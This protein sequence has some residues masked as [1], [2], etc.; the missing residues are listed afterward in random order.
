MVRPVA[1]DKFVGDHDAD[2]DR[3]GDERPDDPE[4][5][6]Q[7][8]VG[9]AGCAFGVGALRSEGEP[10]ESRQQEPGR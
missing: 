7:V 5:A 3:E 2:P 9:A 10:E 6:T 8:T 4:Q 1:T